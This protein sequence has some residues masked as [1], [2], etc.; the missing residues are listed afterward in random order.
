MTS[1]DLTKQAHFM[2]EPLTGQCGI[3]T[4]CVPQ[5]NGGSGFSNCAEAHAALVDEVLVCDICGH[6]AWRQE[7]GT[8]QCDEGHVFAVN[9]TVTMRHCGDCR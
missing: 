6:D 8:Y 7:S 2:K 4:D 1:K 9:R 3:C 5:I